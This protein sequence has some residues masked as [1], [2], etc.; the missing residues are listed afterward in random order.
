MSS[1]VI[2]NQ[3][4]MIP[5]S[6]D[7]PPEGEYVLI[8]A[9]DRPWHDDT[10]QAH[11]KM[12]VAKLVKGISLKEREDLNKTHIPETVLSMPN[13]SRLETCGVSIRFGDE[14]ENNKVPYAWETFGP[15]SFF[16]QEV[17]H[18]AYLPD[19]PNAEVVKN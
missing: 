8:Y 13:G 2:I 16:G 3:L 14:H 19:E 12:K 17:T 6:S 1:A 9:P 10:D 7:L 18:W 15:N 11:V 4:E 5:V